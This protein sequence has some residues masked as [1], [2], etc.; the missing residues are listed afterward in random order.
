MGVGSG[1]LARV[2]GRLE[3]SNQS[4]AADL[5]DAV[6]EGGRAELSHRKRADSVTAS[7]S[8]LRNRR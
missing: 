7:N 3:A 6:K 4:T 8:I 2:A 5:L 1:R